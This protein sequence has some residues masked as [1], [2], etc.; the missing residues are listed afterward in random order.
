M[1]NIID[2]DGHCKSCSMERTELLVL[3]RSKRLSMVT[4][5]GLFCGC[6]GSVIYNSLICPQD[7][8][9]TSTG[10]PPSDTSQD[11]EL[12]DASES[13]GSTV[14]EFSR[15]A[16]TGDNNKDVQFMVRSF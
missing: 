2:A 4:N 3:K 8:W 1:F 12:I 9:S 16:V 10:K 13:D 7:L 15:D 5:A 14:V 6:R 11:Y